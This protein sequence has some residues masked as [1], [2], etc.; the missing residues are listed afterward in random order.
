VIDLTD[1]PS[2]IL[3]GKTQHKI[4]SR[5]R[6]LLSLLQFKN[7]LEPNFKHVH[8]VIDKDEGLIESYWSPPKHNDGTIFMVALTVFVYLSFAR[9]DD[10][11]GLQL[12]AWDRNRPNHPLD[13]DARALRVIRDKHNNLLSSPIVLRLSFPLINDFKNEDED[14]RETPIKL[15]FF[16]NVRTEANQKVI[17]K[18][19]NF[20]IYEIK[21]Y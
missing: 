4:L 17:I 13:K 3:I 19:K 15:S 9:N 18:M 1:D 16:M 6:Q 8:E 11:Y 21:R 7:S 20:M 5:P 12:E 2:Y 14:K 10:I